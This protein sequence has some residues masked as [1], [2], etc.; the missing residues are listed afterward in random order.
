M[1]S[2]PVESA[3]LLAKADRRGGRRLG[4]GR[5]RTRGQLA[6]AKAHAVYSRLTS[7]LLKVYRE[8]GGVAVLRRVEKE[9]PTAFAKLM[10][11]AA[12]LGF[13][14]DEADDAM[15]GYAQQYAL[16]FQGEGAETTV[17]PAIDGVAQR[18]AE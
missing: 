17:L 9:D 5:R 3:T 16:N 7:D 15:A 1:S 6:A 12:R 14:L 4:A 8:A 10:L 18:V 13:Q 11:E 2:L